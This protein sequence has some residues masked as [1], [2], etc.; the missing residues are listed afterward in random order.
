MIRLHSST[1]WT[2]INKNYLPICTCKRR[3]VI[4]YI[5][6]IDNN[7]SR[8]R[9]IRTPLRRGVLDITLCYKVCQWLAAGR[10]FFLG[11]PVSSTN[12]TDCQGTMINKNYLPICTC[13]R[14][15]VI[16]Y[17]LNID[18][19]NS[20]RRIHTIWS[21]NRNM[22]YRSCLPVNFCL[23]FDD[24]SQSPLVCY[25]FIK[26]II[27]NNLVKP[28]HTVTFIKR[29]HFSCPVIESFIWIG[30]L[31]RGHLS[32]KVTFSWFQGWPLNTGSTL[33]HYKVI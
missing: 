1:Y 28:A 20:R 9:R 13:K 15:R 8:R 3:R 24:T 10:W 6:N 14:R 25:Y 29:S 5:L 27:T 32:Y 11:T 30:P 31:L 22:Q 17:I 7:N 16:I 21:L 4:I 33:L 19:N 18:N 2:M 26:G 12:K 23:C